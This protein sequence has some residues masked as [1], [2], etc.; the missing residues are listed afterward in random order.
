MRR[1]VIVK[2][3]EVYEKSLKEAQRSLLRKAPWGEGIQ[4]QP[5]QEVTSLPNSQTNDFTLISTQYLQHPPKTLNQLLHL[6]TPPNTSICRPDLHLHLTAA[7]CPPDIHPTPSADNF[8]C[9]HISANNSTV[10]PAKTSASHEQPS[11][12]LLPEFSVV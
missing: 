3:M 1:Q 10:H 7:T 2:Q 8:P 5:E 4:P 11:L 12:L 6:M 9:T